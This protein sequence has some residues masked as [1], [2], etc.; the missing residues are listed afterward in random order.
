M[1]PDAL[2][3]VEHVPHGGTADPQLL[4]FSA[5]VNPDSPRGVAGVYESALSAS[6]RYPADDYTEFR[7]AAASFVGCEPLHVIP[8]PWSVGGI[9]LTFQTLADE[10]TEVLFPDPIFGEHVRE[11]RVQGATPSF[12][13]ARELTGTDPADYDVAV[14]GVPN[15]PSGWADDPSALRDFVDRARETDTVVVMDEAFLGFTDRASYAGEDGVVVI[16]S[17]SCL[18]GLPGLLTGYLV[19]TG[20]LYTRLEAGRPCWAMSTPAAMVGEYCLR[21]DSFVRESRERV[22]RERARMRDRLETRFDVAPSGAPYLLCEV[23]D[24]GTV[25]DETRAAGIVIRDATDFRGL[26]SHVRITVRRE[27]ENDRLLAALGV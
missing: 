18:F 9:R 20:D 10:S 22:R 11:A 15:N 7:T 17:L 3:D 1:D 24:V 26:D 19:A 5:P 4:D 21:H 2:S 8:V 13:D 12:V 23:D 16:R 25:M 14:V 6:R 27:H